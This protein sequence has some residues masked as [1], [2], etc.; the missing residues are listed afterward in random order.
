MTSFAR[1]DTSILGRWWWT[2]DRWTLIALR[3]AVILILLLLMLRPT[4]VTTTSQPQSRL[5]LVLLDRSRSMQLPHADGDQTRWETQQMLLEQVRG[6]LGRGRRRRKI[7]QGDIDFAY[8]LHQ[9]IDFLYRAADFI[10]G[11]ACQVL[12]TLVET[13]EARG[14]RISVVNQRV[15][16]GARGRIVG[17][18]LHRFEKV[19]QGRRNPAKRVGENIVDVTR[20]FAEPLRACKNRGRIAHLGGQKLIVRA[21]NRFDPNAVTVVVTAEERWRHRIELGALAAVALGIDVGDV[22]AGGR[23][24]ALK[25]DQAADRIV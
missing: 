24:R 12:K 19:V 5:L 15:T 11:I 13:G 21:R 22:V 17:H 1:T 10:A 18:V 8:L 23:Q 20:Q 3:V 7:V 14:Q 25:G 6:L 2:V 4:M 9:R 16:R